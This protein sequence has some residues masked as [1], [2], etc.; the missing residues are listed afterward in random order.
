M[1]YLSSV[2]CVQLADVPF[3]SLKKAD[4]IPDGQSFPRQGVV[5]SDGLPKY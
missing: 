1:K 3:L 5:A 4:I 2:G